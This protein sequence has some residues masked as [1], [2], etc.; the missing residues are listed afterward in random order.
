M[1]RLVQDI[2]SMHGLKQHR[3]ELLGSGNFLSQCQ[4]L[5]RLLQ[6]LV[7]HCIE[8]KKKIAHRGCVEHK[9]AVWSMKLPHVP[10]E[11][12]LQYDIPKYEC[13]IDGEVRSF[14]VQMTY[15]DHPAQVVYMYSLLPAGVALADGVKQATAGSASKAAAKAAATAA[16]DD[17]EDAISDD[18][19]EEDG[20][21]IDYAYESEQEEDDKDDEEFTVSARKSGSISNH[22]T[23][24]PMTRLQTQRSLSPAMSSSAP[25]AA[26]AAAIAAGASAAIKDASLCEG[27]P[28]QQPKQVAHP[29]LSRIGLMHG[30]ALN[31]RRP[32]HPA[33][34]AVFDGISARS[35]EQP[36][37]PDVSLST[38]PASAV[39]T[40]VGQLGLQPGRL[41]ACV[42]AAPEEPHSSSQPSADA[43][44]MAE[45][46]L[47]PR[48]RLKRRQ[49][50]VPGANAADEYDL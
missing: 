5:V 26:A 39:N 46:L 37:T 8:L 45:G 17:D 28:A 6:P 42:K 27:L 2:R 34:G 40:V 7:G 11:Q 19:E 32:P 21:D 47:L 43:T 30:N 12:A 4:R 22:T 35:S 33:F 41:T 9:F 16:A 25:Q 10:V 49:S 24:R 29:G 14:G 3:A 31:R 18:D 15:S 23:H 20:K 13:F 50:R 1:W 48:E 36:I 38:S 44:C